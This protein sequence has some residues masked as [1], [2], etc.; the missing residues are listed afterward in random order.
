MHARHLMLES[1]AM[2]RKVHL[3]CYGHYGPPVIAF[4][5]AAG[6]AHE[7]DRHG[8]FEV[9][10]PL[11][12]AGKV[13]FYCPESNVSQVWTDKESSI[14]ARMQRHRA[15]EGFIL[16]TLVPFIR[17]DC[18]WEGAPM[19]AVG[20]SLGGTYAALFALKYPE[21]FRRVLCMSGRY[22]TT[23]L[24]G[25]HQDSDLYFNN[26][27][28]FVPGLHGEALDRLRRNTHLTLVCGRGAYEEGCIEETIAL[29]QLLEEKGIP[30]VTDIW[31]RESRHDWDWWQ[32]QV[33]VH[34]PRLI[35]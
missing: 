7:W 20:C 8:M 4:P 31:G 32:R 10:G 35:G 6:F 26:P 25:K 21:T 27:L 1:P 28:A 33:A 5:S 14:A 12:R 30:S 11:V 29:G 19:T 2:G 23:E 15:Y 9:L 17:E 22:L 3:W 13:K 34:L 18:R 24:T 16:D